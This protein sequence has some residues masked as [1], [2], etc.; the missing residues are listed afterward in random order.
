MLMAIPVGQ[1]AFKLKSGNNAAVDRNPCWFPP[2]PDLLLNIGF[3]LIQQVF[4]S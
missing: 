2:K 1:L 4:I 3:C